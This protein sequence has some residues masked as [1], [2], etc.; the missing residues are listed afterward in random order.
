M[1]YRDRAPVSSEAWKEIDS[2]AV[3]VL[4]QY[5]SARKAVHVT[6]PKGPDFNAV[7]EGRLVNVKE[8]EGISYGNYQIVP[9]TETRVEFEMNRW[10]LD[11]LERG[12]KD[13]DFAPLEKAMEKM[14]LFEERF[15]FNELDN[16]MMNGP[17]EE[18][19]DK[20]FYF[21]TEEKDIMEAVTQGVL[22]LSEAY[23]KKPYVLIVSPEAYKR[24]LAGTKGYPLGRRIEKLI[25]G[26]IVLNRAIQGAYLLPH[27]HEDLELTLG[28]DFSIGYQ[29]HDN[30]NVK[31]FAK[32]SFAFRVLDKN[33]IVKYN[34]V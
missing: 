19:R 31:F 18:K 16:A 15:I 12:A 23:A 32:E 8:E 21:G 26:E 28:Q 25:D 11:N 2:R 33:I 5:L 6:G 10:E 20:M 29:D 4:K 17:D 1:L 3:E 13:L 14:A 24:I 34:L 27:D 7:A 30:Y 22:K 9:L